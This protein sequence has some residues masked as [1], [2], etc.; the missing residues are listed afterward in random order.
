MV[1]NTLEAVEIYERLV[2]VPEP[3]PLP[4]YQQT[5]LDRFVKRRRHV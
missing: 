4:T 5:T 1:Q 3:P 2:G